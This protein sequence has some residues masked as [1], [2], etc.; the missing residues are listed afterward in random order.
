MCDSVRECGVES[1]V[2]MAL[3]IPRCVCLTMRSV[4]HHVVCTH[5]YGMSLEVRE[6]AQQ[7]RSRILILLLGRQHTVRD[8]LD[9]SKD[10]RLCFLGEGCG[11]SVG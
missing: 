7:A 10:I 6:I 8:V 3:T 2:L 9:S 4:F 5:E 11:M 1:R